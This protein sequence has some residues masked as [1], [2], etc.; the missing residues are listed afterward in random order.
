MGRVSSDGD[1]AHASELLYFLYH[2]RGY[3][4]PSVL[5][6]DSLEHFKAISG[7]NKDT[8]MSTYRLQRRVANYITYFFDLFQYSHEKKK[9]QGDSNYD[10]Y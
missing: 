4:T 5:E 9:R 10:L 7:S 2:L 1:N 3:L 8:Y 6:L